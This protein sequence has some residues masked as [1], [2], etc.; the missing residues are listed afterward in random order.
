LDSW[1]IRAFTRTIRSMHFDRAAPT[2]TCQQLAFRPRAI[3]RI[4][5]PKLVRIKLHGVP[6]ALKLTYLSDRAWY[7]IELAMGLIGCRHREGICR[8]EDKADICI[9]SHPPLALPIFFNTLAVAGGAR[10]SLLLQCAN[11]DHFAA[12]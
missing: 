12:V 9:L 7:A 2:E 10:T 3:K 1:A 4:T 5:S 6:V 11:M 8:I